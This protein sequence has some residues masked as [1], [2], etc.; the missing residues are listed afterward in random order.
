MIV[1]HAAR[2]LVY[3]LVAVT[4]V[5]KRLARGVAVGEGLDG[6]TSKV[7]MIIPITMIIL[8]TLISLITFPQIRRIW[9]G[10]FVTF[11]KMINIINIIITPGR[12]IF[13]VLWGQ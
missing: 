1:H 6:A 4:E 7:I 10:T 12:I 5:L 11:L 3:V 9:R 2:E 13:G 8:I